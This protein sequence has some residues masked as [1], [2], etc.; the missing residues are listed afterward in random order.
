MRAFDGAEL[1]GG[2]ADVRVRQHNPARGGG[3]LTRS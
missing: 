2:G 3:G 1:R